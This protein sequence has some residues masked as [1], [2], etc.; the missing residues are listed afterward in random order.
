M[1]TF[2]ESKLAQLPDEGIFKYGLFDNCGT[3]IGF[4]DDAPDEF[5]KAFEH[6]R[7]IREDAKKQ[8]IIL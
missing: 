2:S 7:K 1:K 6:S 5:K 3:L 8:G 4:K